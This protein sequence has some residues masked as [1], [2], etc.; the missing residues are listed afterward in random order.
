DARL[1][2]AQPVA[3]QRRQRVDAVEQ[4]PYRRDAARTL[5]D[6]RQLLHFVVERLHRVD[7]EVGALEDVERAAVDRADDDVAIL[8]EA[9]AGPGGFA[10][11]LFQGAGGVFRRG[12]GERVAP[13]AAG[14]LGQE[15]GKVR[16]IGQRQVVVEPP[17][18]TPDRPER[19]A[20]DDAQH[21]PG[22]PPI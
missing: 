18:G 17:D 8:Q 21:Q 2:R 20:I 9:L 12:A 6:V 11:D 14:R 10:P 5:P 3:Q 16:A 15:V 4:F 13:D 7:G 1:E 22:R 19:L